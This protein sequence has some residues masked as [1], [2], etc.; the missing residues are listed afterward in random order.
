MHKRLASVA[1]LLF[2]TLLAGTAGYSIIEDW[3]PFDALYMTVITLATVGYGETHPL[4]SAGRVFTLFLILSG[5]SIVAYAFSTLTSIIVEGQLSVVLKRRRMEREI[6]RLSGHYIV[7]GAS[8]SARVIMD[9]LEKTGRTFVVVEQDRE[10]VERLIADGIKVVEGDATEE[11]TLKRAGVMKATGIFAVL[12]TD[13][14]NA[15][16]ALTA[17]GLNPNIRVVSTQRELT[18]RQQLLR[19]SADNV[20]N[21]QY[22]GGLRMVS[23]MVR[24]A[25]VGFLDAMMR[26]RDSVVRFDEVAVP[27]GSPFVGR[28]VRDVKGA[29]GHAPLLVAVLE[30]ATGKYDINPDS[31]RPIKAGDRLVMIGESAQLFELRKRIEIAAKP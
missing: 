25:T 15:F 11:E 13:Q 29:E 6:A 22:I 17:K 18:V 20:I 30:Q 9:E 21:P 26:E 1:G 16:L 3:A 8:H 28:P 12:S 23:E 27:E 4:T 7:C 24:P 2:F 19:S 5:V 10:T 14:Y 31:G